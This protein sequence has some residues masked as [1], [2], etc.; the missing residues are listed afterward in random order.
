M[1]DPRRCKGTVT[2]NPCTREYAQISEICFAE[3]ATD[4]YSCKKCSYAVLNRRR[5]IV[6]NEIETVESNSGAHQGAET[7]RIIESPE[8]LIGRSVSFFWSTFRHKP[9]ALRGKVLCL[10]RVPGTVII[11][12]EAIGVKSL[13][14]G[15]IKSKYWEA[16]K[17]TRALHCRPITEIEVLP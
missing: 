11:L 3:T 5:K 4:I 15:S 12:S 16:H 7:N 8:G 9:V 17:P 1:N 14:G 13:R 6:T 2:K 10:G